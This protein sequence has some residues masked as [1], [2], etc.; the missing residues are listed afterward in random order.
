MLL[1]ISCA[2]QNEATLDI[3]TNVT[4]EEAFNLIRANEGNP[5]FIILDVRTP[6]EFN[7]GHIANALMID[8]NS[9]SFKEEINKLD[10]DKTYLV[11]CRTGN[12]SRGA[13][14]LMTELGF[15]KIYH[16]TSGIVGWLE[17]GLLVTK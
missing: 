6:Q 12:R 15:T 2:Q 17:A 11:Y 16:L 13:V 7:E 5:A 4:A 1:M 9:E 14:E 8:F 3:H 10:K